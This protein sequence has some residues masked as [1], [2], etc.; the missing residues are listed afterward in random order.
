MI[1]LAMT[2][3]SLEVRTSGVETMTRIET[4]TGGKTD[5]TEIEVLGTRGTDTMTAEKGTIVIEGKTHLRDAVTTEGREVGLE[6]ATGHTS[7][8]RAGVTEA[9]RRVMIRTEIRR[10]QRTQAITHLKA[11][12]ITETI[13]AVSLTRLLLSSPALKHSL[14]T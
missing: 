11:G 9:E 10:D 2:R 3:T 5:R 14:V 1:I 6:R 12:A 4:G 8:V 7:G 13:Q